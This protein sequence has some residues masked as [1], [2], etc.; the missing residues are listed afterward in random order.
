[1]RRRDFIKRSC[2]VCLTSVALGTLLESCS[3]LPLAKAEMKE[4]KLVVPI[5][6]FANT[7]VVLIKTEKLPFDILLRKKEDNTFVA[8]YLKCTHQ[9]QSLVAS[10]KTIFCSAHGSSFDMEGN[11]LNEPAIL[12][13]EK[14]KT[15]V[16]DK[17]I[18]I[19]V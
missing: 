3:T 15:S 11:V 4:G 18:Y 17:M 2:S 5:E 12:P 19:H 6:K 10:N 1:M 16:T 14:F 13:L 8:L 7:N 9:D